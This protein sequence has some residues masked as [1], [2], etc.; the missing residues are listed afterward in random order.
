MDS[1]EDRFDEGDGAEPTPPE[2]GQTGDGDGAQPPPDAPAGPAGAGRRANL[3]PSTVT[4]YSY[5]AGP[6]Y[7]VSPGTGYWS[8]AYELDSRSAL[9]NW[10][11][12]RGTGQAGKRPTPEPPSRPPYLI[13]RSGRLLGWVDR[14][15]TEVRFGT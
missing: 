6:I 14:D 13:D 5:D 9:A 3:P 15:G 8:Y 12:S 11:I 7:Q 4:T 2:K 1:A 10:H